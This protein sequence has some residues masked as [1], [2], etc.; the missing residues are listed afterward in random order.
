V[1]GRHQGKGYG[2]EMLR[3]MLAY[4]KGQNMQHVHL[5]CLS[6]NDV[7]NN[8]YRSEGFVEVARSLRWWITL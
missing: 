6:D 8:L 2:R 5:E 7:G 4:M 3:G 1:D